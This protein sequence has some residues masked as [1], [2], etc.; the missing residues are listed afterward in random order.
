METMKKTTLLFTIILIILSGCS[1]KKNEIPEPAKPTVPQEEKKQ[2]HVLDYDEN[3]DKIPSVDVK[4]FYKKNGQLVD[5]VYT[6]SSYI[7]ATKL[8]GTEFYIDKNTMLKLIAINK[9]KAL[10]V[11]PPSNSYKK[12][13]E[14]AIINSAYLTT[15]NPCI[16]FA[17]FDIS[18]YYNFLDSF[19]W[20]GKLPLENY[21]LYNSENDEPGSYIFKSQDTTHFNFIKGD[22]ILPGD[23]SIEKSDDEFYIT[24][25]VYG[26]PEDPFN[27]EYNQQYRL[28]IYDIRY[29]KITFI[30]DVEKT[31]YEIV[32]DYNLFDIDKL[33]NFSF[34][35]EYFF[36]KPY[37]IESCEKC[38][39]LFEDKTRIFKI[40]VK[41][42]LLL[43][44]YGYR[45]L[46]DDYWDIKRTKY[47]TTECP[48]FNAEY[49]IPD[50]VKPSV[51]KDYYTVNQ[52]TNSE[53]L[54][55]D[56]AMNDIETIQ[57]FY[58]K[59]NELYPYGR[60]FHE[61][62]TRKYVK[63]YSAP[64]INSKLLYT[65]NFLYANISALG[66]KDTIN[67]VTSHWVEIVLPRF[68]WSF[69]EPEYGWVFGAD[70]HFY[71]GY[72]YS[73]DFSNSMIEDKRYIDSFEYGPLYL[74]KI[75]VSSLFTSKEL[76]DV[77]ENEET[78]Y[79][80]YL[81]SKETT[82]KNE[83]EFIKSGVYAHRRS[84]TEADDYGAALYLEEI[85]NSNL[86]QKRSLYPVFLNRADNLTVKKND[87]VVKCN[88]EQFTLVIKEPFDYQIT[89]DY[90]D[91]FFTEDI[92]YDK[93]QNKASLYVSPDGIYY[94]MVYHSFADFQNN[95]HDAITVLELSQ[96]QEAYKITEWVSEKFDL[97]SQTKALLVFEENEPI[98]VVEKKCG[99]LR[100]LE[101]LNPDYQEEIIFYQ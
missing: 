46:Y 83:I 55:Y 65:D 29:D 4:Q 78:P 89:N 10:I 100:E 56:D 54:D 48:I 62:L 66:K 33:E 41:Y 71:E 43:N 50:N 75:E 3:D 23:Y 97:I 20:Y 1:A 8:S 25:K 15:E 85:L 52:H 87:P 36:N 53:Q 81:L 42:G 22:L 77:N 91:G 92:V 45:K 26:N 99:T 63:I 6:N 74:D 47:E 64:D 69:D 59:G 12:D 86:Q 60:L 72:K 95:I 34:A 82:L 40:F 14:F 19:T 16:P 94:V 58:Y 5:T 61:D 11:V 13:P 39:Y 57:K 76:Y 84:P 9:K 18:D 28:L 88:E 67:G 90:P 35:Q 49:F 27:D 7:K 98:L 17:D 70:V 73:Y 51:L 96:S 32:S 68:L 31:S 24:I 21:Y 37:C 2:K 101:R 80:R 44:C 38:S 93:I 79:Y 30:D